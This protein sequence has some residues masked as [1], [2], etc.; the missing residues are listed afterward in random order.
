MGTARSKDDETDTVAAV[1]YFHHP[2]NSSQIG[3]RSY[4]INIDEP[5]EFQ[6]KYHVAYPAVS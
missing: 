1:Y 3:K 2:N 6:L 5:F 4:N